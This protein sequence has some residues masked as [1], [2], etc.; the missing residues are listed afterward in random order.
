M[1]RHARMDTCMNTS[2]IFRFVQLTNIYK[3][4]TPLC[5]PADLTENNQ[6]VMKLPRT[7]STRKTDTDVQTKCT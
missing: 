5:P 6:R 3:N 4:V 1:W 2:F 7:L